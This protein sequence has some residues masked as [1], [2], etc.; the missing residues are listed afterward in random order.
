MGLSDIVGG[1]TTFAQWSV[2]LNP[3]YWVGWSGAKL[4]DY[5]EQAGFIDE[6]GNDT[7]PTLSPLGDAGWA[8]AIGLG[9]Y[10]FLRKR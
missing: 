2:Y 3:L 7:I 6:S 4:L 10:L 1:I 5:G 9:L 8:I